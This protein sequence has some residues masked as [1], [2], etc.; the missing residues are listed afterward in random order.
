MRLSLLLLP[1]IKFP[2][3]CSDAL[4]SLKSSIKQPRQLCASLLII[5]SQL[6]L[7]VGASA[8]A[9]QAESFYVVVG[10]AKPPYVIQETNSGFEIELIRAILRNMNRK[11]EFVYVP[12]GRSSRMLNSDR[13]DAIM[14]VNTNLIP[15]KNRLSD[16]YIIYQNVVVTKKADELNIHTVEDLAGLSIAAFQSAN[17]ILGKSFAKTIDAS[18]QY[19]EIADQRRQTKLLFENKVQALVM[20]INIF[21]TLS[22]IVGGAEDL[23][24]VNIHTAF[25][26]NPYRMAFKNNKH[27]EEFNKQLNAYKN[28]KAYQDLLVKYDLLNQAGITEL[29]Q[30]N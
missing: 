15:E 4:L 16:P 19:I 12:F 1:L 9:Q 30:T 21:N 20:D 26:K 28:S 23:S 13:I 3:C 6:F 5:L 25:K 2:H 24:D 11:A 29:A 18:E 17:K 22:P 10:L 7:F 14:T 8:Q 27:I